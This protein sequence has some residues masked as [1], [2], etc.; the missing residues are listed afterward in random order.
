MADDRMQIS[1]EILEDAVGGKF[2]FY[3]ANDGSQKCFVTGSGVFETSANGFF[4]YITMRN[5]NPGLSEAEYFEM[6]KKQGIIW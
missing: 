4:Q 3:T 2:S 5:S 6:A 1:D